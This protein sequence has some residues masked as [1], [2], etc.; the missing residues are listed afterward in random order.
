MRIEIGKLSDTF[1]CPPQSLS[2][3]VVQALS[4]I[5]GNTQKYVALY[6]AKF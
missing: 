6:K 4:S 2:H 3:Q 1:C 5:N